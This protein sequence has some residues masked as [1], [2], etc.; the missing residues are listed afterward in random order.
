MSTLLKNSIIKELNAVQWSNEDSSVNSDKSFEAIITGISN[1]I[2]SEYT[3]TGTYTAIQATVPS[4]TPYPPSGLGTSTHSLSVIDTTW[5]NIFKNSVRTGV[6]TGGIQRMFQGIQTMLLG[7]VQATIST[8]TPTFT[9][10]PPFD[11]PL[12]P[13]VF[14]SILAFG[15]PCSLE[16]AS[17]KPATMNDAWTI[18][19]KYIQQGLNINIVPPIPVS[20]MLAFPITGLVTSILRFN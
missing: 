16:I 5:L 4:P 10:F 11:T 14:P 8:L 20:G 17:T 19:A 2:Q 9:I 15:T 12:I 1:Y 3:F 6:S 13:V 18:L 7:T